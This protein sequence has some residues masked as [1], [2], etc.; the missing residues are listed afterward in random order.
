MIKV[1]LDTNIFPVKDILEES[2]GK[3]IEYKVVTVTDREL[4]NTDILI[5]LSAIMETAVYGESKYGEAVYG[6]EFTSIPEPFIINESFLGK[7][8]IGS[9]ND[10]TILEFLLNLISNNAF[11]PKNHR[12]TLTQGNRRQ[13]RD[14]MIL[15]AHIR[16]KRDIFVTNDVKGFIGE[17]EEKRQVL[18]SLFTFRI[19]TRSE[20]KQGYLIK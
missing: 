6:A 8:L 15:F 19:M 10:N 13:L 1:T 2:R 7:A 3:N 16:E 4:E 12:K 5:E 20:F 17:N 14:A 18:E 11:P 9:K